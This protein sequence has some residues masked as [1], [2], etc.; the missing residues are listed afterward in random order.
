MLSL[1]RKITL[2]QFCLSHISSYSLSLFK[3]PASTTSRI[4]KLQRDFLWSRV[5]EGKR[6]HLSSWDLVCKPKEYGGLGLGKVS[7]RNCAPL[8]KWLWRFLRESFTLW[9]QAISSIYGTHSNGWDTNILVRWLYQCPWK[10]IEQVFHDFSTHI[11]FIVGA[12]VRIHF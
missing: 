5:G 9:H 8:G 11:Y 6:D 2:I 3:I 1:S 10:V 7:L 4:R 12:G